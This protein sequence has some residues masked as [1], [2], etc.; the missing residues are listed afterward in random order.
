MTWHSSASFGE[1]LTTWRSRRALTQ[2]ALAAAVGTHRNTISRWERGEVLP[3][4]KAIV[5]ELVRLLRLDEQEARLLLEASLT[6]LVPYWSVP[7]WRNPCFI[8]RAALLQQVHARLTA[9]QPVA[10]TQALALS[11]LGGIGKTQLAVEYAYRYALEYTAVFWLAAEN[12]ESVMRSVQQIA[13]QLQLPERQTTDQLQV[14]ALVRRWLIVH[15]GWLVIADNVE[16][17]ALLQSVLP[18]SRHGALLLTTRRQT[19]GT[20]AQMLEVPPLGSEEGIALLLQRAHLPTRPLTG[21]ETTAAGEVVHLL[22]GLPLALDQ[23]GAYIDESKC[24]VAEYLSRYQQHRKQ[25]LARRGLHGGSHPDSVTTTLMLSVEQIEHEYPGVADLLRFCAFLHPEAIPEELLRTEP[26]HTEAGED[27]SLHDPYQLDLALAALRSA[28]VITRHPETRTLSVH[29]LVQ[30]VLQDQMEPA[31]RQH[32]SHRVVCIL[33]AAFPEPQFDAWT[34]CERYLIQA[35]ACVV[36]IESAGKEFPEAGELLLKTGSY[37]LDR[38]RH[39]EAA[40][41]LAQAVTLAEQ[42]Y[43]PEQP[44][45]I[46]RLEKQAQLFCAQGKYRQA[47]PLLYRALALGQQHLGRTHYQVTAT[48]SNLATLLRDQEMYEQAEP[49]F[50]QILRLNEQQLGAEHPEVA[51]TLDN[52]AV[53]YWDQGKDE[54][55]EL[56]YQRALHIQEQQL[57]FEHPRTALTLN[58]LAVLYR[59]QGK[60][61]QAEYL[62]QQA[63]AIREQQ[64]GPDHPA[65]AAT[66]HGLAT[67]YRNQGKDEQAEYLFQQALAIRE[68]QLGPGHPATAM[69]LNNLAVLYRNQGKD[70]QAECLFQRALCIW[71]QQVG[72]EHSDMAKTLSNLATLYRDQEKDEQAISLYQRTQALYEQKWG[73][74][75]PLTVKIRQEYRCLLERQS[76]ATELEGRERQAHTQLVQEITYHHQEALYTSL[77]RTLAAHPQEN[78]SL[79]RFLRDCC[80]LH[81][82]AWSRSGELWQAYER[83]GEEQQE[84]YPLSRRA[85][86]N[87]LKALGCRADRTTIARIWRGIAI[88]NNTL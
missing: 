31:E 66:L 87:Q 73:P 47:E 83:W 85:F 1:L 65:T 68:Q 27:E 16:D 86:T 57:G 35:L 42:Q 22:D 10:L 67:L 26:S 80:D 49:L 63:L 48:L 34:Q 21:A 88:V 45:L 7:V 36:L 20:L 2:A 11:G 46:L 13:H 64:L 81:P 29:R 18:P 55:A 23:A 41:L 82:Q 30:A 40:P 39:S 8:G 78:N 51:N 58:N 53:L 15:P 33:N 62:F 77:E 28:S 59:N 50:Q 69:T 56:L 76:K 84:R 14:L 32:W 12:A 38:G 71:E 37:L 72:P 75:H 5:L 61:E 17:L 79:H 52:L 74:A 60:D 25:A 4:S 3:E 43:G 44:L 19:L 9:A 24:S 54:Q 70:E 6:A